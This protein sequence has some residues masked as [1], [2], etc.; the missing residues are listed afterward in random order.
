LLPGSDSSK[1]MIT[2]KNVPMIPL[3][4]PNIKYKV[5]ISLW[6]VENNQR[7]YE[8]VLLLLNIERNKL[9]LLLSKFIVKGLRNC[10][11]SKKNKNF[12][13]QIHLFL[14]VLGFFCISIDWL[15][16]PNLIKNQ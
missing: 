12:V 4:A 14:V 8:F 10:Y 16:R 11:C 7:A 13:N 3:K 5:P 2:E 1:R 15:K 6:L 9:L